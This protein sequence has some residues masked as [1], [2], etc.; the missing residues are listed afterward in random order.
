MCAGPLVL[1]Q[2]QRPAQRVVSV[3]LRLTQ[4]SNAG[5][6]ERAVTQH[7]TPKS[8]PEEPGWGAAKMLEPGR[9]FGVM[10]AGQV[11]SRSDGA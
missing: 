9:G 6:R 5:L 7:A 1:S 2:E 3:S 11:E 8:C 4:R 10:S